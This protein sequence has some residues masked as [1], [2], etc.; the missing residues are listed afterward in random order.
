M[1]DSINPDYNI[2]TFSLGS[3]SY[4]KQLMTVV[5]YLYAR[6]M[7]CSNHSGYDFETPQLMRKAVTQLASVIWQA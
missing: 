6:R 5:G 7:C 2:M 1:I 4:L 3:Y